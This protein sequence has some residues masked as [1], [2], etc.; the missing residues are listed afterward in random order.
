MTALSALRL[1]SSVKVIF[2]PAE[3]FFMRM[4]PL[5]PAFP[6]AG[7]MELA[8]ESL[9]P[10]PLAQLYWGGWVGP[11][12]RVALVYAA[13]RRRFTAEET[14]EWAQADLVVPDVLPLLGER[15]EGA[16]LRLW[17]DRHRLLGVAWTMTQ[18][19][20]VAVL[21]RDVGAEPSTEERRSFAG[22]LAARAGCSGAPEIETVGGTPQARREGAKWV[23]ELAGEPP[24]RTPVAD[25]VAELLDVRDRAFQNE[26]RR[27]RRRVDLVWRV[28][29]GGLG[30][31]AAALLLEIAAVGLGQAV[32][33]QRTA[34]ALR[35]PQVAR[36]QDMHALA[37]RLEDLTAHRLGFLEMLDAVNRPRPD[38]ILF[39]H[40]ATV[41]RT[42]L[43]IQ[44]QTAVPSDIVA[45][46]T[47]LR[48][49]PGLLSVE[50]RELRAREGITT[51]SLGIG[52]KPGNGQE[53]R[54][55]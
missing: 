20:P 2:V 4:V 30:L 28:L 55:P 34:N 53:E 24:A 35:A 27:A 48:L 11:E 43:E 38:S 3:R 22:E 10:F 15:P 44:A 42:G 13:H 46:E 23:F 39:T 40:V 16:A 47:A 41:G 1:Q 21:A 51:F 49:V 5:D 29:L 33:I 8:L 18:P 31:A 36:L 17:A 37:T 7:Q 50:T 32:R 54:V 9:A 14:A 45:Y 6:A 12:G 25:D 52:F 26:R 19:G